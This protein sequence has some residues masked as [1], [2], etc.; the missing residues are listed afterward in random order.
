MPDSVELVFGLTKLNKVF[1]KI[2]DA[3]NFLTYLFRF[4]IIFESI[5]TVYQKFYLK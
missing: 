2:E 1:N 5:L 4:T 3:K